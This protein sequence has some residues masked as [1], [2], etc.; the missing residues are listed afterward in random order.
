MI[1]LSLCDRHESLERVE[2]FQVIRTCGLLHSKEY[3]VTFCVGV[4]FIQFETSIH[5]NGTLFCISLCYGNVLPH[6]VK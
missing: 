2:L 5:T 4:K 1:F 6:F 3:L